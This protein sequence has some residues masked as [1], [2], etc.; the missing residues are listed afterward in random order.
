MNI[1]ESLIARALLRKHKYADA[2]I[3]RVMAWLDE[4]KSARWIE[5]QTGMSKTTVLRIKRRERYT[6]VAWPSKAERG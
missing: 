5:R 2:E 1:R 6:H 4:G 3:R